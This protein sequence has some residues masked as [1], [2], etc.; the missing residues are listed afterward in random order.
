MPYKEIETE[1]VL[2]MDDDMYLR[3]DEIVF[4]FRYSLQLLFSNLWLPVMFVL[5]SCFVIEIFQHKQACQDR[6]DFTV[7]VITIY[8]FEFRVQVQMTRLRV[9]N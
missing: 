5:N 4:A 1:A 2:S 3:H 9:F 7:L 8:T 6:V